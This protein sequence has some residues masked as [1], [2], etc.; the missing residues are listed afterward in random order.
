MPDIR[1]GHTA[2]IMADHAQILIFGGWSFTSQYSNI[3]IYD[4]VKNEWIDPEI[5]H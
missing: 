4:I 5:S 1:G 3:M 2:T